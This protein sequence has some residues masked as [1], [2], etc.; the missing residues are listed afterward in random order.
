LTGKRLYLQPFE[1]KQLVDAKVWDQEPLLVDLMN[2]KFDVILWYRPKTW[3]ES[4]ESR[5]SPGQRSM[6]NI[7][8]E[9]D[10]QIGDV[11]VYRPKK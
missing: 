10:Q 5:W 7:A 1:F 2:K 3:L 4:I 11:Y 8:Y 9:L 6:V